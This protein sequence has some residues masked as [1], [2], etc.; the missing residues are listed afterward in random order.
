MKEHLK[1]RIE[2]S[3]DAVP[4][5]S[6][7]EFKKVK[8]LHEQRMRENPALKKK[9]RDKF[10]KAINILELQ[11]SNGVGLNMDFELRHFLTEFNHRSWAFG[12]R[13][14]PI[15]F[16][17]MEAFF[18]LD[19]I[20][21]SWKLLEEEDYLISFYDFLDFYT[22]RDFEFNINFLKGNFEEDLIYNYNVGSQINEITF[23]TE[24]G[25]EFVIA[26]VSILRRGNE[27]TMLFLA[28]EIMDTELKTNELVPLTKSRIPG[29]EKIQPAEGRKRE[30]V[31]LNDNK[32]LWK[33]LMACRFDLETET[34]D[35]RY[36]AKDEG[37]SF[38]ILTD[39]ITGFVRNGEWI[40]KGSQEI[41]EN[42]LSRVEGYGSIFELAKAVLY[43]PYYFNH[44]EGSIEEEEH[45]TELKNIIKSP[46]KKRKYKD[47]ESKYK[48]RHR[49]L[50]MLNKDIRFSEDRIVLRDENFKIENGGYWKTL[51]VEEFGTDKKGRQITGKTWVN[52]TES[53]F[54][55]KNNH[56]IISNNKKVLEFEGENAGFI[57]VMR[58]ATF[59]KDIY[60][61]GL[62]TK[63]TEERAKQLSKTSVPDKFSVMREWAVK[64]CKE[65]EKEIHQI[66]ESYRVDPRRE[67]FRLDMKIA[68]DAIDEVI[69]KINNNA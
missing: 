65:A 53:F 67:F 44:F 41:Y 27:V 35:A 22:S 17:I 52:K 25:S 11:D 46:I 39:D 24:E 5:D 14:M 8:V 31:R 34:I 1:R 61:I 63:K 9:L 4:D 58:N 47:V 21:N 36:I 28:G 38:S 62:T 26:G 29:K 33:V 32:N 18:D 12:H 55:A 51:S 30:A 43:L 49:S 69:S 45:E 56:L 23:K 42:M 59:E 15:M 37:N 68:N 50:W 7:D 2:Y 10:K 54:Q 6:T 57:Y 3:K 48:I 20:V 66:L 60:K 19:K 16:N 64:D 40:M 13:K